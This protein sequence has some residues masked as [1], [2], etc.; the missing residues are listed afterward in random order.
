MFSTSPLFNARDRGACPWWGGGSR[1]PDG[2]LCDPVRLDYS[3]PGGP[4]GL[5]RRMS[6]RS[7]HSN[8]CGSSNGI[9]TPQFYFLRATMRRWKETAPLALKFQAG[10]ARSRPERKHAATGTTLRGGQHSASKRSE[11]LPLQIE[12]GRLPAPQSIQVQARYTDGS[13]RTTAMLTV[14]RRDEV[15]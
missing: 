13:D 8:N 15:P 7:T 2:V 12:L 11:A 5:C 1:S 14:S 9:A 6:A 10:K 3:V 4:A